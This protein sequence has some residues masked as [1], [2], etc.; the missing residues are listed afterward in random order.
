MDIELIIPV[1]QHIINIYTTI[2]HKYNNLVS[3][4]LVHIC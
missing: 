1:L 4:N 3:L 2:Q